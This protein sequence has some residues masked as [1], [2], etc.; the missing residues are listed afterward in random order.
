MMG[1][2]TQLLEQRIA[3]AL[4]DGSACSSENIYEIISEVE[5]SMVQASAVV[6][7]QR[8]RAVDIR[9]KTEDLTAAATQ[10]ITSEIA[11]QRLR[12]LAS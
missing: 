8:A 2:Q 1:K 7:Q 3:A 10:I 4:D 9:E 12:S 6:D 11:V 5:R